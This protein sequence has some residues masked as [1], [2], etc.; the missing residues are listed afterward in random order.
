MSIPLMTGFDDSSGNSSGSRVRVRQRHF[1]LV[2][3]TMTKWGTEF[4][5]NSLKLILSEILA[6]GEETTT[7]GLPPGHYNLLTEMKRSINLVA[8][9]YFKV[10]DPDDTVKVQCETF[11]LAPRPN[12]DWS[13]LDDDKSGGARTR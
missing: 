4:N 3:D 12:V 7:V 8:K 1:V 5:N 6:A 2:N 13:C 11:P 9:N 10:L